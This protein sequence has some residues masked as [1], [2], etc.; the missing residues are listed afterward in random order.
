[1]LALQ[2]QF[3]GRTVSVQAIEFEKQCVSIGRCAADPPS[4]TVHR[5]FAARHH[6][7]W[8]EDSDWILTSVCVSAPK[9][10]LK[11]RVVSVSDIERL[12]CGLQCKATLILNCLFKNVSQLPFSV[13]ICNFKFQ[14]SKIQKFK[15]SIQN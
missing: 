15:V 8:A 1:M 6:P 9:R 7:N 5:S 12:E 4:E 13:M 10:I 14:N 11:K 3:D 2:F